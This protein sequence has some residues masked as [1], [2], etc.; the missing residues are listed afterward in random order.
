MRIP[1]KT[2][3]KKSSIYQATVRFCNSNF[4]VKTIVLFIIWVI[5]C[6]P[7]YIYFLIRW[8]VDPTG[9]WQEIA[10][11][12]VC[13]LAIGWFQAILLFFGTVLTLM[14]ITEDL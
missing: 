3:V 9:F 12:L 5:V 10:T 11:I 2:E 8:A 14:V 13:I 7:V 6:I 4:V 1:S